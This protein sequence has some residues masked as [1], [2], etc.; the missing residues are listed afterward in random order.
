MTL[1]VNCVVLVGTPE[2]PQII[3]GTGLAPNLPPVAPPAVDLRQ[4]TVLTNNDWD[5]IQKQLNRRKIEGDRIRQA[6]EEKEKLH[7]LS[8]NQIKNWANTIAVRN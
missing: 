5:R 8:K 7:G 1:T 6:R 2:L 3:S 4:V